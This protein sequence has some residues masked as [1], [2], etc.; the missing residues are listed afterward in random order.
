MKIK[1]FL[2]AVFCTGI[3]ALAQSRTITGTVSSGT[4]LLPGVTILIKGTQVGTET[5]FDGNYSIQAKQ[6]DVLIFRFLGFKTVEK[7]VG[8]ENTINVSLEEQDNILDEIVVVGFGSQ[9]KRKLTGTSRPNVQ[10]QRMPSSWL[11]VATARE[12]CGNYSL[13]LGSVFS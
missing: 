5:D 4:E 10:L 11:I 12:N 1:I 2:I 8:T 7:T 9:S 3:S 13:G 6:G